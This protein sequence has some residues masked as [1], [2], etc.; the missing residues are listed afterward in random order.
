MKINKLQELYTGTSWIW[1][2]VMTGWYVMIWLETVVIHLKDEN[3][4]DYN[5]RRQGNCFCD[6]VQ[7]PKHRECEA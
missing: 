3:E 4:E 6:Q 5:S 1:R 2:T 7:W